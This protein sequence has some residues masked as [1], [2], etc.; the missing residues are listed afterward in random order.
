ML[1]VALAR[2]FDA[3][4]DTGERVNF[5]SRGEC[6]RADAGDDQNCG[7]GGAWGED[8]DACGGGGYVDR[9]GGSGGGWWW[10]VVEEV[11]G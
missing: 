7:E 1:P 5:R 3:R 8:E 6:C 4:K 2:A 11:V 10:W 9:G